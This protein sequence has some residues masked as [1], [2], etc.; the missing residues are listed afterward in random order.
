MTTLLS[1]L[2]QQFPDEVWQEEAPLAQYTYMKIGGPAEVLWEAKHLSGLIEVLRWAFARQVPVTALGGASNVLVADEG[3]RGLVILNRCQNQSTVTETEVRAIIN[4]AGE[5]WT[6][7]PTAQYLIAESGVKTALLVSFSVENGLTGLE[8]FLGVPGTVGGAVKNNSHYTTELIGTYVFAV[9][10]MDQQG[11]VYWLN[12]EECQFAYDMSR[13]HETDEIILQTIFA[14]QD[15]NKETSQRLIVEATQK[16]AMTQPLGTANS[17]CMF[18]NVEL[19][20]E[21]RGEYDGKGVL[22]AGWLIDKAGLKG[23]RVGKAVVSDKHANFIVNEGG[24]SSDDVKQLVSEIQQI[25]KEQYDIDLLP[26]VFFLEEKPE[27]ED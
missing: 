24:A 12:H 2:R 25:I 17:G 14:L 11:Q 22:S 15:G 5:S 13:F 18:K 10:V 23:K 8:P 20:P 19:P 1:E 27:S 26:E 16:R 3:I 4:G 21:K 7:S 9:Q 6:F